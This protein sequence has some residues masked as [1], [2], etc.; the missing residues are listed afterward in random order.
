MRLATVVLSMLFLAAGGLAKQL[1]EGPSS[2]TLERTV[3]SLKDSYPEAEVIVCGFELQFVGDSLASWTEVRYGTYSCLVAYY[4]D[5]MFYVNYDEDKPMEYHWVDELNC[6]KHHRR[7][8]RCSY[9]LCSVKV[10]GEGN[11]SERSHGSN[12]DLDIYTS[13]ESDS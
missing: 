9:L 10:E 13:D 8:D 12:E 2:Q 4:V 7:N 1:E 3:N 6:S 5:E 11:Y